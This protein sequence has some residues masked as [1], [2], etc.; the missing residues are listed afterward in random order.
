MIMKDLGKLENIDNLS[1]NTFHHE[2]LEDVFEKK[3]REKDYEHLEKNKE[4]NKFQKKIEKSNETQKSKEHLHTL[5]KSISD[6]SEAKEHKHRLGELEIKENTIA[7]K[8]LASRP[9]NIQVNIEEKAKQ[10]ENLLRHDAA[11][12]PNPIARFFGKLMQKIISTES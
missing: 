7:Y 5:K 3:E 4:L 10:T 9:Y 1:S 12:D 11:K 2:D 8:S 6:I